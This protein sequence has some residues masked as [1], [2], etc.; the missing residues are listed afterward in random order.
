MAGDQTLA[1]FG[2]GKLG[3]PLAAVMASRGFRVIGVDHDEDH[4]GRLQERRWPLTEPG[5]AELLAMIDIKDFVT[6]KIRT[7]HY[8]FFTCVRLY[9]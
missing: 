8:N 6:S 2:L 3:L 7:S 4:V 5:L 9:D 1:V